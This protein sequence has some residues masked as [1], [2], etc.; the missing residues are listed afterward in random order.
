M[1]F[2]ALYI[3]RVMDIPF[4]LFLYK[5]FLEVIII[6]NIKMDEM[7]VEKFFTSQELQDLNTM[8]I[9]NQKQVIRNFQVHL[10]SYM[11]H[12]Y[13]FAS[14]LRT[15]RQAKP[16]VLDLL[17]ENNIQDQPKNMR[18]ALYYYNFS[19]PNEKKNGYW[20]IKESEKQFSLDLNFENNE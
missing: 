2:E 15:L 12:S 10:N 20:W 19:S 1:W 18:I 3:E 6:D 17:S 14:F 9:E 5:R 13:W 4:S 11:D 8:D 16:N 7:S